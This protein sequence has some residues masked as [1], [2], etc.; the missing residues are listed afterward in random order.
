MEAAPAAPTYVGVERTIESI[1]QAWAAPGAKVNPNQDGW[2]ALFDALLQDLHAYAKAGDDTERLTALN[3]VYQISQALGTVTW[4]PAANLREELRQWLRPRVRLAWA[5]QRLRDTV[6]ALPASTDPG[7]QANRSRW[8]DFVQN[9]LGQALRDY[10]AAE[11]V[12]Q[13]LAALRRVH[14]ALGSLN[15]LNQ[16]RFWQPS[17][18]LSSAVNDLFNQRNLDITAD[19][20]TVAPV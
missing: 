3:Q 1:R 8:V 13:R 15:K 20:A 16:S 18:E 10:D 19:V 2:N 14:E 17:S 5:R 9:D 7:I 11:S 12:S 4:Q 6:Q